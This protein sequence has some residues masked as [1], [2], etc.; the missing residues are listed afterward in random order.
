MRRISASQAAGI[1]PRRVEVVTVRSGDT[2]ASLAARMAFDDAKEARFRVL[3]G[4]G[5]TDRVSA[6]QKVKLVVRT[7]S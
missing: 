1:T 5:A 2:V 3:N 6:G 7:A 4:L